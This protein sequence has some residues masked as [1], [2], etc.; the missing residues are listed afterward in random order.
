MV[1]KSLQNRLRNRFNVA[2]SETGALEV[3]VRA[4]ITVAAVGVD[5]G[6]I[7]GVLDQV[8]RFVEAD[9]RSLI[10]SVRSPKPSAVWMCRGGLILRLASMYRRIDRCAS[11]PSSIPSVAYAEA[12]VPTGSRLKSG[13]RTC[14]ANPGGSRST[15][16]T[17]ASKRSVM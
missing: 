16:Q 2:V 17:A 1:V 12:M 10:A 15:V 3:L 6:V 11:S 8:D 5:R 4:E 9:G 13:A 14:A 7:E